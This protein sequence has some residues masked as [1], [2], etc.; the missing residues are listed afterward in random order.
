M[1][2]EIWE[3]QA[4]YC[5]RNAARCWNLTAELCGCASDTVNNDQK[6]RKKLLSLSAG[7]EMNGWWRLYT[8]VTCISVEN[9]CGYYHCV[10]KHRGALRYNRQAASVVPWLLMWPENTNKQTNQRLVTHESNCFSSQKKMNN[11]QRLSSI[12]FTP[13]E[14][15]DPSP[16]QMCKVLFF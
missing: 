16:F 2:R 6:E 5:V 14:S 9:H 3:K 1:K 8:R 13:P 10:H 7:N 12:T 11:E 4:S 15:N